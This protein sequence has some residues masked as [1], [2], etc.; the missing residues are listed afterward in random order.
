MSLGAERRGA[1]SL[2]RWRETKVLHVS[3]SFVSAARRA[4]GFYLYVV[5][6]GL[7]ARVRASRICVCGC[8]GLG[9]DFARHGRARDVKSVSPTAA[10]AAM[11]KATR[12]ARCPEDELPLSLCAA[13]R[14]R[15]A[16]AGRGA[17]RPGPR[18]RARI[19]RPAAQ[20]WAS[21]GARPR[22]PRAPPLQSP[23]AAA[24]ATRAPPRPLSAR[25]GLKVRPRRPLAPSAD[26]PKDP[27]SD[28]FGRL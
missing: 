21:G 23:V 26:T 14:A 24:A 19:A 13:R 28:G 27:V 25:P 20:R 12:A 16:R 8:P 22:P 11:A 5:L 6:G 3:F 4:A 2:K 1:P 18:G 7:H 9:V 17:A 15:P 10:A